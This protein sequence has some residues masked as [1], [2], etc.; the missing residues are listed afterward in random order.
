[1]SASFYSIPTKLY[2]Y[3][4]TQRRLMIQI[5]AKDMAAF[6]D[7]PIGR[8]VERHADI[9]AVGGG[10]FEIT[11]K[12]GAFG[13]LPPDIREI[14]APKAGHKVWLSAFNGVHLSAINANPSPFYIERVRPG[15]IVQAPPVRRP[16]SAA[17]LAALANRFTQ[18]A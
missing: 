7:T 1:M 2:R 8:Q 5:K 11:T 14:V 13:H 15:G 4:L 9:F 18:E 3:W 12:E 17:Q 10:W 6:R 16:A